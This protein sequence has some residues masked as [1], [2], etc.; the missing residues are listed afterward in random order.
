MKEL[1]RKEIH[2]VIDDIL[3]NKKDYQLCAIRTET[4]IL[5]PTIIKNK[6]LWIW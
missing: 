2:K 6:I 4:T 5:L 3:D 1:T